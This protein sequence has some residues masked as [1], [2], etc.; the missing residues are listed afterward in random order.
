MW[1]LL[2]RHQTREGLL[3]FCFVFLL[4]RP[5]VAHVKLALDD[6]APQSGP[7]HRNFFT[8]FRT[9]NAPMNISISHAKKLKPGRLWLMAENVL[10]P[11]DVSLDSQY[12]GTFDVRAKA[13]TV[14]VLQSSSASN[15]NNSTSSSSS[16]RSGTDNDGNADGGDGD[17]SD[18]DEGHEVHFVHV[19]QEQ[20][21]GWVGD[22][23][24][25]EEFDRH[26]LGRVELINSLSPIK[27]HLPKFQPPPLPTGIRR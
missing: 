1:L 10:G 14:Q 17:D 26:S 4:F 19:S 6:N 2:R 24:R 13:S 11:M 23:R 21:R 9:F 8:K 15:N 20:T 7:K 27:L 3:V 16:A 22:D 5:I 25:P 18:D 12:T